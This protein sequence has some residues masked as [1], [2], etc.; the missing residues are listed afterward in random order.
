M[1]GN[2]V[3]VGAAVAKIVQQVGRNGIATP[4]FA[5]VSFGLAPVGQLRRSDKLPA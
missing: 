4:A 3:V 2:S 1:T 5:V